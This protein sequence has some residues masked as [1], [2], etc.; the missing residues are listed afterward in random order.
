MILPIY[1]IKGPSLKDILIPGIENTIFADDKKT[2]DNQYLSADEIFS[3]EFLNS[4]WR[5][6]DWT[7]SIVFYKNN[8]GGIHI[9]NSN[10]YGNEWGIN[11]IVSGFGGI[12]FWKTENIKPPNTIK[13]IKNHYLFNIKTKPCFT[14]ETTVEESPYLVNANIPHSAWGND[15]FAVSLRIFPGSKNYLYTEPWEKIV[16]KFKDIIIE[17]K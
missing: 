1:K 9:D 15:R 13:I 2:I 3:Q 8:Q 12:K 4:K 14:T 17:E 6:Y 10:L 5:G 7:R 11:W 16:E